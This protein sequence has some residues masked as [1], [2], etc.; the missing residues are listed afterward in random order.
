MPQC[1]SHTSHSPPKWEISP[2]RHPGINSSQACVSTDRSHPKPGSN[3]QLK[4]LNPIPRPRW[5][6]QL[7]L[8]FTFPHHS[9]SSP[10]PG[11]VSVHVPNL[12][13]AC[14]LHFKSLSP[15]S[16]IS[17]QEAGKEL[18]TKT[19]FWVSYCTY[20]QIHPHHPGEQQ[21]HPGCYSQIILRWKTHHQDQA[22]SRSLVHL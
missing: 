4:K 20:P 5:R 14:A 15:S 7:W 3:F 16:G 11:Y 22:H 13:S 2:N 8:G 6:P 9:L 18:P 1:S 12:C 21:R 17:A 19:L 10:L